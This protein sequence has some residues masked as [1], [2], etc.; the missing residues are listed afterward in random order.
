MGPEQAIR[1]MHKRICSPSYEQAVLEAMG[2]GGTGIIDADY[3]DGLLKL[4]ERLML[5][6]EDSTAA[7]NKAAKSRLQ[8][9]VTKLVQIFERAV[10]SKE[11]LAKKEGVDE[12]EDLNVE[13]KDTSLGFEGDQDMILNIVNIVDWFEGNKLWASV[14]EGSDDYVYQISAKGMAKGAI[15]EQ[16]YRKF[17][18]DSFQAQGSPTAGGSAKMQRIELAKKHF[19]GILALSAE[20]K[21]EITNDIGEIVYTQYVNGMLNRKGRIEADD[22]K[23]LVNLQMSLQMDDTF[24]LGLMEKL[25]KEYL[26]K[27]ITKKISAEELRL[28][29]EG[30]GADVRTD[31]GLT[32]KARGIWFIKETKDAI[33]S[34]KVSPETRHLIEEIQESWDVPNDQASAEF[35]NL[36]EAVCKASLESAAQDLNAKKDSLAVRKIENALKYAEFLNPSDAGSGLSNSARQLLVQSY[37]AATVGAEDE[38]GR[39]TRIDLLRTIVSS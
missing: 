36:I 39:S 21:A 27:L 19:A 16:I 37:E 32:A 25:Q 12:G 14:E 11:E 28:K 5:A 15:L 22:M 24:C 29:A 7:F 26:Q 3:Y 9:M 13:S 38:E 35:N 34:G 6:E 8:L 2:A 18:V 31:L 20:K 10:L 23:M 30:L 33:D 17:I 4:A 1:E